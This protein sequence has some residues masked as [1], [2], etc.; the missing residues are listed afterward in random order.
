MLAD[1]SVIGLPKELS[2]IW[3]GCG[4]HPGASTAGVKLF[5]RW[6]VLGGTWRVPG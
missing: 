5:V 3:H 6:D 2:D 1:S 4:G